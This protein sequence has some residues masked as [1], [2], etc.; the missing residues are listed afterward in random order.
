AGSITTLLP[1]GF[2]NVESLAG[3]TG[4]DTFTFGASGSR[5]GALHGGGGSDTLG[6]NNANNAFS[7]TGAHPGSVATLLPGRVSHGEK[8]PGGTGS[9]SFTFGASGSLAGTI[10]GDGG[11]D[12]I[13]GNNTGNA[14]SITGANAGSIATLLPGG[15]SNV[16]NLTGGTGSDSFTF[17]ASGS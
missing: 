14:F 8:L 1:G 15:F 3:G 17:G 4:A 16:E 12:T 5:A 9:D 7:I 10:D 11:T 6:G 13:T 2:T